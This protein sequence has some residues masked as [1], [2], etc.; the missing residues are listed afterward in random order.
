MHGVRYSLQL[1]PKTLADDVDD[2]RMPPPRRFAA[3][4]VDEARNRSQQ[5]EDECTHVYKLCVNSGRRDVCTRAC[6]SWMGA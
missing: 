2:D 5:C 4:L 3:W 6:S 1:K